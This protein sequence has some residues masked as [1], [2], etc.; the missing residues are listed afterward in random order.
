MSTIKSVFS[1]AGRQAQ[2]FVELLFKLM[3]IDLP[4][5]DC[6]TVSKRLYQYV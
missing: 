5:P 3:R 4:V 1:W 2:G 6:S